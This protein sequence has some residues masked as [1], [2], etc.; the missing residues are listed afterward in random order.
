[1]NGTIQPQL[2]KFSGNF[3]DQW[4]IQMKALFGFQ[5]LTEIIE[6]GYVEPAD[7]VAAAA[8]SQT[9]K[10][11]LRE[12]RKKDKKVLFFLY[13]AVD[14]IVFERISSATTAKD[15]WEM[16]QKSYKGDEKVKSV[17]LQ[18][19]R[20]EFETLS[21]KDT[22]TI[23]DYFSRVQSAVNQLRV[24]GEN[25]E[26]VRVIEKIMRSLTNRF[27][28]VVGAIEEERDLSTRTIEG[29]LGS[30]CSHEHRIN[31]KAAA[32][33][34]QTF[35]SKVNLSSTNSSSGDKPSS[36][37][38]DVK[39]KN[40]KNHASIEKNSSGQQALEKARYDKTKI[41]C[42]RCKKFGHF[43]SQCRIKFPKRNSEHAN[44]T[45]DVQ[46]KETL[47]L[48]CSSSEEEHLDKWY[49]DTGCSNHMWKG[50]FL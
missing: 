13:Q 45:D 14:E 43:R 36:Q 30:L 25:L 31:H 33:V 6:A 49:L 34:E 37:G 23:S 40:C 20:G 22:E 50:V 11:N 7:Q 2:P 42:F 8:L 44:Y 27:D 47:L 12:N 16:L 29:L 18:T 21:M 15:A 4:C 32:P 17:R 26:D 39:T 41:Q 35:Q 48:A 9:Q 46:E 5:E 28:Y 3:F 10:D 24:N 19:L 1:M 38:K